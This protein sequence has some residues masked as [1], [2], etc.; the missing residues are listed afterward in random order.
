MIQLPFLGRK[1]PG[2][3]GLGYIPPESLWSWQASPQATPFICF[4]FTVWPS[5]GWTGW[6]FAFRHYLFPLGFL[7]RC[8]SCWNKTDS[9]GFLPS[10]FWFVSSQHHFSACLGFSDMFGK[11]KK[12]D[13]NKAQE[14]TTALYDRL[15]MILTFKAM[16]KL[17]F[18]SPPHW[19][20]SSSKL[21]KS[22]FV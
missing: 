9:I 21:L 20:I 5:P 17:V 19:F 8:S 22:T 16:W 2:G 12:G 4:F 11:R 7:S 1:S 6:F 10:P 15:A 13:Q 18:L 3:F 14:E